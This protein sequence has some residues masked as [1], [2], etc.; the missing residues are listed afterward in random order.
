MCV[1]VE[2]TVGD[3]LSFGRAGVLRL[4]VSTI[5]NEAPHRGSND[6]AARSALLLTDKLVIGTSTPDRMAGVDQGVSIA[7]PLDTP[8]S[9][10]GDLAAIDS[11]DDEYDSSWTVVKPPVEVLDKS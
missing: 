9:S 10:F 8:R 5:W 7:T 3:C 4:I 1:L 11:I 2:A 6:A